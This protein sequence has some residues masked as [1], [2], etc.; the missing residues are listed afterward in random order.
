MRRRKAKRKEIRL[1]MAC[2][3]GEGRIASFDVPGWIPMK[4]GRNGG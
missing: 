3:L 2:E 1:E 4:K